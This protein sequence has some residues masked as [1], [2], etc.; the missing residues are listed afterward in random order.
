MK[1]LLKIYWSKIYYNFKHQDPW[2]LPFNLSLFQS[3]MIFHSASIYFPFQY[4]GVTIELYY[5]EVCMCLGRV[6]N[7]MACTQNKLL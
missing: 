1:M 6:G 5:I 7:I 3:K 2:T 4:I